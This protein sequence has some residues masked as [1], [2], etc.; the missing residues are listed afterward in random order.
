MYAKM[1]NYVKR[2]EEE[3]FGERKKNGVAI[4]IHSQVRKIKQESEKILDWS[5]SQPEIRPPLREIT[6]RQIP[7]SPLGI[8]GRPISVGDS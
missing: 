8:S 7:R 4:A 3:G 5:P 1:E 2:E 6:H